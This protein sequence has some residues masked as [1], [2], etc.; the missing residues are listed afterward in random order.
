MSQDAKIRCQK[1]GT[2]AIKFLQYQMSDTRARGNQLKFALYNTILGTTYIGGCWLTVTAYH[3]D[4][5]YM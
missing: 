4:L 5:R 2:G 3:N 1:L